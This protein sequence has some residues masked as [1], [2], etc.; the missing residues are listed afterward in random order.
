MTLAL[1]ILMVAM[2]Y[3]VIQGSL[4][5]QSL[6]KR[7]VYAL[8][9]F[10]VEFYYVSAVFLLIDWYSLT[11]VLA[12]CLIIDFIGIIVLRKKIKQSFSNVSYD[13]KKEIL[14]LFL[15]FILVP[16]V[17]K[18]SE[19]FDQ[20]DIGQY[21]AKSIELLDAG[22]Q[23]ANLLPEYGMYGE[24]VDADLLELENTRTIPKDWTVIDNQL[25]YTYHGIPTWTTLLTLSSTFFGVFNSTYILTVL[26]ILVCSFMYFFLE[27]ISAHKLNKY[28]SVTLF[29]FMP[30]IVY[31]AKTTLTELPFLF[32]LLF[33][34]AL[35]SEHDYKR[36]MLSI[37]PL[38]LL[39]FLHVTT[40][41]YLPA[42]L[43]IIGLLSIFRDKRY[44]YIN[45]A[46][47]GLF[48]ISLGYCAVVS[49]FYTKTQLKSI[50]FLGSLSLSKRVIVVT[51]IFGIMAF[52][53]FTVIRFDKIKK[54]GQKI[55]QWLSKNIV[56]LY[57][58]LAIIFALV[59]IWQ[60]YILGFT[61][62]LEVG[63][64]SW[65]K[66]A[67][68][69]NHGW[70]SLIHLNIVSIIMATGYIALPYF[71][72]KLFSKKTVWNAKSKILMGALMYGLAVYILLRYS[73]PD[74]PYNYFVSR[75]YAIFIVPMSVL[76]M[77]VFIHK[78]K[79]F[80]IVSLISVMT[81]LPFSLFLMKTTE[82]Q[83]QF[84]MLEAM[85]SVIPKGS[86][87]LVENNEYLCNN[88][89]FALR[90]LNDNLVFNLASK[91]EIEANKG[92]TELYV[93]TVSDFQDIEY[94][95]VYETTFQS[96]RD[97]LTYDSSIIY[98]HKDIYKPYD[99]SIYQYIGG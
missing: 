4:N 40:I 52:I 21:F 80:I 70:S 10:I 94:E 97:I 73:I 99:I 33:G 82:F 44:S 72:Y 30:L 38:G 37:L 34:G 75:Y 65:T 61:D 2:L 86:K 56:W 43:A 12:V 32:A 89:V 64:G 25:Q 7:I 26:Y 51:L 41:L 79:Q 81:A 66:R 47:M 68:Y 55:G 20:H 50:P 45:L 14:F 42:I 83:G 28:L 58:V 31:L 69:V 63:V 54:M 60:G 76:L 71:I 29:G 85:M 77:A 88:C 9:A 23:K 95:K 53:Q 24:K 84:N 19:N 49:P 91:S 13:I 62:K 8:G 96:N 74:T 93:L 35:L 39:G 67:Y 57:R 18:K 17:A 1:T 59:L 27:N 15:L 78:R 90:E 5:V 87:V 36:K 98:P 46:I 11:G 6:V 22:P 16:F 92:D 48:V 3:F